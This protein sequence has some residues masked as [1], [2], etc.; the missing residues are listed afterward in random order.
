MS[1]FVIATGAAVLITHLKVSAAGV[2]VGY[3]AP[4]VG[5]LAPVPRLIFYGMVGVAA[6][7]LTGRGEIGG[8]A[9]VVFTVA[10]F[11]GA[12]FFGLSPF[13]PSSWHQT[14]LGAE[15]SPM[16]EVQAVVAAGAAALAL[17]TFGYWY[18]IRRRDVPDR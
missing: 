18:M 15:V 14:V 10:D 11:M 17:T 1:A 4:G 6:G 12:S 13:F 16:S 7:L 2:S 9:A 3:P 8:M 5:F